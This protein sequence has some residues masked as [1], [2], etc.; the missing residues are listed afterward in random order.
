[1][2]ENSLVCAETRGL[3]R[4]TTVA[5]IQIC[6]VSTTLGR[7]ERLGQAHEHGSSTN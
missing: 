5:L 7:E 6:I 2:N 4:G 3:G 1:M